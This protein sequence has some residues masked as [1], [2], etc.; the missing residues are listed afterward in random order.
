MSGL[1]VVL[2]AIQKH[3][4]DF[5]AIEIDSLEIIFKLPGVKK[6]CQYQNLLSLCET[7]S[8]VD[9][10]YDHIFLS[11]VQN[12]E[13]EENIPA[14]I[15]ESISKA[16]L[17][18]SGATEH[19]LDY[20]RSLQDQALK[21]VATRMNLMKRTIISAFP[22]YTFD[23]M[24]ELEYP[25]FIELF[26]EAE[27]VLIGKGIIEGPTDLFSEEEKEKPKPFRVEDVIRQDM[28]AQQNFDHEGVN[29]PDDM[30][31]K[32]A[33][34]EFREQAVKRAKEQ[35]KQYMSHLK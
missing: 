22:I 18:L 1:S 10:I 12:T 29:S 34:A 14:G 28:T 23:S 11:C 9:L 15:T 35:E 17:V 4:G 16:I 19:Y 21:Q 33:I 13:L 32:K 5:Y 25:K 31:R 24:D 30:E 20:S 6:A 7:Q 2:D 8:Q 3:G 27:Q 26:V